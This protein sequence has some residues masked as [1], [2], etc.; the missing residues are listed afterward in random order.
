MIVK[1]VSTQM[2]QISGMTADLQAV[3]SQADAYYSFTFASV[4][5]HGLYGFAQRVTDF[6]IATWLFSRT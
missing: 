5:A 4:M 2:T 1:E 3:L 6:I